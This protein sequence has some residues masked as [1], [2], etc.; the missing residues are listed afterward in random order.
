MTIQEFM[1]QERPEIEK[2]G[3]AID[4]VWVK[5]VKGNY[6]TTPGTTEIICVNVDKYNTTADITFI[7]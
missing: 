1:E 4:C 6:I 5:D 3:F 2:E 7:V